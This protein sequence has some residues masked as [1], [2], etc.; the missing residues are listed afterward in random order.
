MSQW[1]IFCFSGLQ[2]HLLRPHCFPLSSISAAWGQATHI[3]FLLVRDVS[4]QRDNIALEVFLS[5]KKK[6]VFLSSISGSW[7][8]MDL[9]CSIFLEPG[10][11]WKPTNFSTNPV[12]SFSLSPVSFPSLILYSPR[13]LIHQLKN[14]LLSQ[15][16]MPQYWGRGLYSEKAHAVS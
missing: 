6:E 11:F 14:S 15:G 8:S 9:D 13:I 3:R 7:I 4:V 16:V 10:A 2:K 5:S 1:Y 12:W